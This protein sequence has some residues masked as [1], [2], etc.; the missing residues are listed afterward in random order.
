[1][2]LET[3]YGRRITRP[4]MLTSFSP[5]HIA[6]AGIEFA[7]NA[8]IRGGIWRIPLRRLGDDVVYDSTVLDTR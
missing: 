5:H 3:V 8:E 2:A 1:M 7:I 6:E 4:Y